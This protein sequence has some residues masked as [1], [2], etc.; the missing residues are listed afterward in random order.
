MSLLFCEKM[1]RCLE[2]EHEIYNTN[3]VLLA[4]LMSAE[5]SSITTW[6]NRPQHSGNVPEHKAD[7]SA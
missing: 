2:Q 7:T 1:G 5:S 3:S 6:G 4:L